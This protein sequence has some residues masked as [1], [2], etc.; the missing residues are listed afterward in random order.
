MAGTDYQLHLDA[1]SYHS[2]GLQTYLKDAY[3]NKTIEL[4]TD[5]TVYSFT[6]MDSIYSDRFSIVFGNRIQNSMTSVEESKSVIRVFPNPVSGNGKVTVAL[7]NTA[8]GKY[9]ITV[10]NAL[11]QRLLVNEID[12]SGGSGNYQVALPHGLTQGTLTV[13]VSNPSS[14]PVY[15]STLIKN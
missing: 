13:I 6:A 2:N 8:K 9:S 15:K 11:G 14:I 12:H 1:T 5:K 10:Y 7:T 4:G 3:L